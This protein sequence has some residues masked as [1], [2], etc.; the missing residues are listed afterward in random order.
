MNH[1]PIDRRQLNQLVLAAVG[2]VLAGAALG[3]CG[4]TQPADAG[5]EETELLKEP[6]VCR[7]L[8]TCKGLG[9]GAANACAGQGSCASAEAHGC[10]YQN[11]C[12]GQG[13]C[14]ATAGRNEC[15]AKGECGVPLKDSTWTETRAAFE[16]A[17]RAAGR[18]FGDAPQE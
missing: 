7:G 9:A 5:T 17:M 6:H 14:G 1:R 15:S 18:E 16:T 13:G 2:G 11:K 8:N 3:S 10:H 12:S 4:E